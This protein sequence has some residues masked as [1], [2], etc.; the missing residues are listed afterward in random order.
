MAMLAPARERPMIF[1]F[2]ERLFGRRGEAAAGRERLDA[3]AGEAEQSRARLR[4][5]AE[6]WNRQEGW[7]AERLGGGSLSWNDRLRPDEGARR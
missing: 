6:D 2:L 5:A 1:R 4:R 3:A 7:I